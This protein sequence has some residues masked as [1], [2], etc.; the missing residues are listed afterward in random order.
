MEKR[1]SSKA[2]YHCPV[3]GEP[4]QY[5]AKRGGLCKKCFRDKKSNELHLVKV[6]AKLCYNCGRVKIGGVWLEREG[7]QEKLENITEERIGYSVQ[8]PLTQEEYGKLFQHKNVTLKYSAKA[9]G[10]DI[11]E[12]QLSFSVLPTICPKCRKKLTGNLNEAILHIRANDNVDEKINQAL[13]EIRKIFYNEGRGEYI[14]VQKVSKGIDIR[15][16]DRSIGRK[17][18]GALRNSLSAKITAYSVKRREE[19]LGETRTIRKT[20]ILL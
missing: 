5:S 19:D 20:K 18:E 2:H 12:N 3:C 10:I 14:D 13:E 11:G 6:K 15:L 16:S 1:S 17:I 9:K 4:C 7:L 8:C